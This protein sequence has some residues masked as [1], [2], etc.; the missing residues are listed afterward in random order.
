MCDVTSLPPA[1]GFKG[2]FLLDLLHER[3]RC[4]VPLLQA[5]MQRLLWHCNTVLYNQ[6]SSWWGGARGASVGCWG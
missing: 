4:G 3:A 1:P 5:C 2:S 6:L